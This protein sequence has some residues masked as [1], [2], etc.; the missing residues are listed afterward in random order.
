LDGSWRVVLARLP[1]AWRH[2]WEDRS[3]VLQAAGMPK[4]LAEFRAYREV[5]E[6]IAAV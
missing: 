5:V 4:D 2:R 3:E 1:G 6:E